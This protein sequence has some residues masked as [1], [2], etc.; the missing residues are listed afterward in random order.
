MT[1]PPI[2]F[3]SEKLASEPVA[4]VSCAV[5]V[6]QALSAQRRIADISDPVLAVTGGWQNPSLVRADFERIMPGAAPDF[7]AS[8]WLS[9]THAIDGLAVLADPQASGEIPLAD[10]ASRKQA[11]TRAILAAASRRIVR[12][13]GKATDGV[14]SQT[15][16]RP[17]SRQQ[18]ALTS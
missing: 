14:V 6:L 12:G 4:G 18:R 11:C 13:T 8:E 5:R 15:I 9:A 1:L 10:F 17:I 3:Q 2:L 16:N 7:Q